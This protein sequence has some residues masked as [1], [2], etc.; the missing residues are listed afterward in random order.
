MAVWHLSADILT[1]VPKIAR[2]AAR[3]EHHCALAGTTNGAIALVVWF[4]DMNMGVFASL[5]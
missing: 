3:N 4:L 2:V 1:I 5:I